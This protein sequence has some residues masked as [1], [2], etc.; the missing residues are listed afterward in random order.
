MEL[1]LLDGGEDGEYKAVGFVEISK[2]VQA[3][4]TFFFG[5]ASFD[6]VYNM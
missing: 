1:V 2:I 4:V 3:N 6:G 5:T